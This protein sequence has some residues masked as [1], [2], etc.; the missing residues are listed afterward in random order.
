MDP[1]V[2]FKRLCD[3][4]R[5]H[6]YTEDLLE[7]NLLNKEWPAR[8]K[9]VDSP[10]IKVVEESAIAVFGTIIKSISSAATGPMHYFM[11]LLDVPCVCIG[12]SY[13]YGKSH[14]PN[15]FARIDLLNKTTK[16]I[17]T[18]IE[19]FGDLNHN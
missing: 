4:F 14:S 15:E 12:S 16:C 7:I 2:Q 10:F 19:K 6:G 11:N 3:H 18:I 1:I 13:K 17:S 5:N 8:T 9:L